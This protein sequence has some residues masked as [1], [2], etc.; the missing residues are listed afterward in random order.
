MNCTKCNSS[1]TRVIKT[2][3]YA[4]PPQV[5]RVR[6][7]RVCNFVFVTQEKA[8]LAIQEKSSVTIEVGFVTSS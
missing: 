5:E 8:E 7:C 2:I 6:K 3:K 4:Q 1:D